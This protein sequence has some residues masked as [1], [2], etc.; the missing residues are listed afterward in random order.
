MY[1]KSPWL[2]NV[3]PTGVKVD[4]GDSDVAAG[5]TGVNCVDDV[6][7][8]DGSPTQSN[9]LT[10]D[11]MIERVKMVVAGAGAGAGELR[12]EMVVG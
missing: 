2:G 7:A 10:I 6:G 4:D 12:G 1:G 5:L 8:G 11:C 9:A 3:G